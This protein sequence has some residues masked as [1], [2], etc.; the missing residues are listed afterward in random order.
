M[1]ASFPL[2]VAMVAGILV[3]VSIVAATRLKFSPIIILGTLA[4]GLPAMLVVLLS[5]NVGCLLPIPIIL[6]SFLPLA[7]VIVTSRLKCRPTVILI[8]AAGSLTMCIV[9][10]STFTRARATSPGNACVN[11][12]RQIDSGKQQWALEHG[13][14]A[15]DIP[16]WKD[17]GTFVGRRR[18]GSDIS[19]PEGGKYI[20]GKVGELPKCSRG[21]LHT[22]Q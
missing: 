10:A 3:L 15:E 14:T 21:G 22:L 13:K 9:S 5:L 16:T 12:L 11:N 8:A 18:D 17:L 4:A 6:W 2:A 20:L 1:S 19:C 7:A